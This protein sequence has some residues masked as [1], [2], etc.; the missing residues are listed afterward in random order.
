MTDASCNDAV[1]DCDSGQWAEN[2]NITLSLFRLSYYCLFP[3]HSP[4]FSVFSLFQLLLSCLKATITNQLL[5]PD[6][7][8]GSYVVFPN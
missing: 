1:A 5:D 7:D 4:S 6:G 8:G 2:M 3:F